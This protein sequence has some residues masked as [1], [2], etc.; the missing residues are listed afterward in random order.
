MTPD[1]QAELKNAYL[2]VEKFP[3]VEAIDTLLTVAR[4][5]LLDALRLAALLLAKV[6]I[7]RLSQ[8]SEDEDTWCYFCERLGYEG[9]HVLCD[10]VKALDAIHD[11]LGE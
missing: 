3:S 11:E 5:P 1:E 8:L 9:H 4:R 2:E 10:G 7:A 6:A